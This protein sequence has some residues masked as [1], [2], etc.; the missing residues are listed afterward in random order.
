MPD[1][2]AEVAKVMAQRGTTKTG[3]ARLLGCH[4]ST[5]TR[6]LK[7]QETSNRFLLRLCKALRYNFFKLYVDELQ[8]EFPG[9]ELLSPGKSAEKEIVELRKENA[10]LKEKIS[11][12]KTIQELVMKKK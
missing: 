3:L 5:V 10:D 4:A 1:I 2:G 11:Y 8:K 12:L 7:N 9:D 6:V